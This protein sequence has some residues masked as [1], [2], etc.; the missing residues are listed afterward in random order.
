MRTARITVVG[1]GCIVSLCTFAACR[2]IVGSYEVGP[3][4][5]A[6]PG[7]DTKVD[8]GTDG[9]AIDSTPPTDSG[10]DVGVDAGDAGPLASCLAY[11]KAGFTTDGVFTIASKEFGSVRAFCDMTRGG[12]TLVATRSATTGSAAWRGESSVVKLK[13]LGDL[14]RKDDSVLD[15]DWTQLAFTEVIYELGPP[16]TP[17]RASFPTLTTA[18]KSGARGALSLLPSPDQKPVCIVDGASYMACSPPPGDGGPPP[19]DPGKGLGWL[20]SPTGVMCWWAWDTS[21]GAQECK[22]AKAGG[23]HVWVK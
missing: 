7:S 8:L 17:T 18:Q 15:I 10:T 2:A 9:V 6:Q 12:Y 1:A 11:F 14:A 20:Y 16:P 22:T 3:E 23:G 21:L 4:H 5:D 19:G 13:D